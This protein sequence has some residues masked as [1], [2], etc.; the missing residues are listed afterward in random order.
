MPDDKKWHQF[1]ISSGGGVLH[2]SGTV[3]EGVLTY[4][5]PSLSPSGA[6]VENRLSFTRHADGSV[7]QFW[8]TSGDSGKTWRVSFDGKYVRRE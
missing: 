8:E 3:S 2:L 1:W 6:V 5:G 7:R 4:R